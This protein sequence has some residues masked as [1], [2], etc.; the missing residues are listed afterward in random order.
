MRMPC[1]ARSTTLPVT[2]PVLT[3]TRYAGFL[4]SGMACLLV[5]KRYPVTAISISPCIPA[6]ETDHRAV[7]RPANLLCIQDRSC[8]RRR[9]G[10]A[11]ASCRHAAPC[12]ARTD[13]AFG[14]SGAQRRGYHTTCLI[15]RGACTLHDFFPGYP[16]CRLLQYA[17]LPRFVVRSWGFVGRMSSALADF[18]HPALER[19][20]VWDMARAAETVAERMEFLEAGERTLVEP[21]LRLFRDTRLAAATGCAGCRTPRCERLGMYLSMV[22]NIEIAGCRA[23]RLRGHASFVRSG[24]CGCCRGIRRTWRA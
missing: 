10:L 5:W 17:A 20:L 19:S 24:R 8:A 7:P 3:R 9:A 12:R 6:T 15:G 4:A 16:E 18:T 1:P 22:R 14:H 2:G 13:R 11:G 23:D 21:F